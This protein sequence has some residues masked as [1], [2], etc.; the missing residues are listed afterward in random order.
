MN[1]FL[2]NFLKKDPDIIDINPNCAN[3]KKVLC[4]RGISVFISI[5][6]AYYFLGHLENSIKLTFVEALLLTGSHYIFEEVW[7]K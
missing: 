6:V 4:W 2:K 3:L 7:S 5:L 1:K